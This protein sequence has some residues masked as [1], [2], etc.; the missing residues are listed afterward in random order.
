MPPAP[1]PMQYSPTVAD[2][3]KLVEEIAA[4]K[5][6]CK[7]KEKL[8]AT[9][10]GKLFA[11]EQK[12]ALYLDELGRKDYVC[13]SGRIKLAKGWHFNLPE[14]PEK[15]AQFFDYLREKGLFDH[16]ATVN[17]ASY[18]AFCKAEM[19]LAKEDG[20]GLE[21]ALPG[22]PEPKPTVKLSYTKR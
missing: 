16:Y 3:D 7:E 17:S 12:A 18:N 2:L 11:L 8:A 1:E 19:E 6:V 9:E 13:P 21:F 14:T 10:N 4:Q 15:K 5:E 20:R 22:V